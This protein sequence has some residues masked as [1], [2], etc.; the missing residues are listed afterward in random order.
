[1]RLVVYSGP[2]RIPT[3]I[4]NEKVLA[5]LGSGLERSGRLAGDARAKALGALERFKILLAHMKV[6]RTHVVATAAIREAEDGPEFVR[7]IERIGLP[8]EVLGSER[9][10]QL[11]GEG[12]LSG[13]PEANGIV[14][15]LVVAASS[16]SRL[17][18]AGRAAASR[19]L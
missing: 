17:P 5:G 10:A 15:D 1:V 6:K 9:E 2:P 12:V 8:C 4:F 14:G 18:T 11:A 16:W 3:P 13:I 7:E 19:R